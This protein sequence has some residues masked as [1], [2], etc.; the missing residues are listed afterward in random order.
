MGSKSG[1]AFAFSPDGRLLAVDTGY[2]AIRLVEPDTG[3]E[4]ARLEDPNQDRAAS[5]CFAPDGTRLVATN[6]D[7]QSIHVWDLRIIREQLAKL[8]LDWD[9]P[10]YPRPTPSFA[11]LLRVEVDLG[12]TKEVKPKD[13]R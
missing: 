10:S 5:I 11:A 13:G 9:L 8:G 6:G 4:Y 3:R 12:D 7:S 2:G 1:R